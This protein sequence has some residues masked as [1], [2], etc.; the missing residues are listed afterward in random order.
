MSSAYQIAMRD[1]GYLIE[2]AQANMKYIA[3]PVF[4][5]KGYGAKGNGTNNDTSFIQKAIDEASSVGGGTVFLPDGTYMYSTLTLKSGVRLVGAGMGVSILKNRFL[6]GLNDAAILVE[7]DSVDVEISNLTIDGNDGITQFTHGIYVLPGSERPYIH[8]VHIKNVYSVGGGIIHLVSCKNGKV[9]K[10]IVQALNTELH[11]GIFISSTFQYDYN[12]ITDCI[13]I[14]GAFGYH[15]EASS[16]NTFS[17]CIAYTTEGANTLEGFNIDGGVNN[18]FLNCSAYGRGDAGYIETDVLTGEH[19]SQNIVNG[20]I[21]FNNKNCGVVITGKNGIYSNLIAYNNGQGA[22]PGQQDGIQVFGT[23]ED[24]V[25]DGAVM[26]DG[27]ITKTQK[28]GLRVALGAANIQI[29]NY[30]SYSNGT[31]D[32]IDETGALKYGL[33]SSDIKFSVHKA[34]FNQNI[35]SGAFALVTWSGETFDIGNCFASNRF[36]PNRAGRYRLSANINYTSSVDLG[37]LSVAFYKNGTIFKE[38]PIVGM[39]GST[40]AGVAADCLV[41]A[42]GTTD[43][44]EVYVYQQTGATLTIDGTASKTYFEGQYIG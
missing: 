23:A 14:D 29:F 25:I 26:F 8:H 35:T 22:T 10:C 1:M 4:N 34:G 33:I 42:N 38:G 28:F 21:A 11:H 31:A 9:E 2:L 44:F 5:V 19:P 40:L 32:I 18:S 6:V 24:I 16:G 43:Y 37:I 41:E 20:F 30:R 7:A 39:S 27:E 12:Q 13:V 15:I 36:T 3:G 17:N